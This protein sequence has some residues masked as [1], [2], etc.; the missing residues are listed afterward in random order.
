MACQSSVPSN[1]SSC[2]TTRE[3]KEND[4]E[5]AKEKEVVWVATRQ[6][7]LP[8]VRWREFIRSTQQQ[9]HSRRHWQ[10]DN[11]RPRHWPSLT[12]APPRRIC[13]FRGD[14]AGGCRAAI[15]LA[16]HVSRIRCKG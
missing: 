15:F 4:E 16:V 12:A 10:S 7:Q 14:G 5:E 9:W 6:Q 13:R 3:S 1:G 11:K 8:S 2:G